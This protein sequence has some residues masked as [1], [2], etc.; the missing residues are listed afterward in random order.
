MQLQRG[1]HRTLRWLISFSLDALTVKLRTFLFSI[2]TA[3]LVMLG[4]P[5]IF[6]R[7]MTPGRYSSVG[8]AAFASFPHWWFMVMLLLALLAFILCSVSFYR[9]DFLVASY[10]LYSSIFGFVFFFF[11]SASVS[12]H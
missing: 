2:S 3:S 7:F 8:E 4:L 5:V 6:G 1:C 9:G 10:A 12:M 11:L